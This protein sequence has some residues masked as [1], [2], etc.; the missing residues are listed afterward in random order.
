MSH[1]SHL[2]LKAKIYLRA[3]L[4][5]TQTPILPWDF[6]QK[7]LD[8]ISWN[9]EFL[10]ILHEPCI[11]IAFCVERAARERIDAHVRVEL[12]MH[13]IGRAGE[14]MRLVNYE[15]DVLVHGRN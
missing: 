3:W 9:A 14:S 15:P 13:P 12:R 10:E 1:C 7:N 4:S 8:M 5:S 6:T 11:Q 2:D